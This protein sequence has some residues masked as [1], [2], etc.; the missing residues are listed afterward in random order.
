M[1]ATSNHTSFQHNLNHY[2]STFNYN[3]FLNTL[4]IELLKLKIIIHR[5]ALLK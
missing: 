1:V 5:F 3:R 2:E 4:I